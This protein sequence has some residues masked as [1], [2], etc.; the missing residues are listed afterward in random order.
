MNS[1]N[2]LELGNDY[3]ENSSQEGAA[4]VDDFIRELE[5]KERD[6][7]IT[8]ELEIE[9]SESEFDD[10]NLPE[11]I[12]EDLKS[13]Q[14]KS[15]EIEPELSPSTHL[16][17]KNQIVELES[18]IQKFKT[19]RT[20][21]LERSR[22]QAQDFEN[23]KNRTERERHE[24]LS[25]QM[26][27]LATKMLPVLDNLDRAMEFVGAMLPEKRAEIEQFVDGISLVHHQVDEVLA[28]MGVR[29][30]GSVGQTFDPHFHEA[31]AIAP[32]TDLPPNTVSEEL[33]RGYQMGNR[34]IRHSMVKVTSPV[35]EKSE[36]QLESDG[37]A[38]AVE[39]QTNPN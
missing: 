39:N 38:P 8:A 29:A 14:P 7:H 9:I 17:L 27:N 33:L 18:A 2:T 26:E 4:S 1:N 13:N 30:I 5:E 21:I 34:V 31:V 36:Q 37:Q 6:L 28:T 25:V 23:F 3:S 15:K 22:R 20:E 12:V 32:S 24:R 35:S 10:S 11:F 16:R 19:E